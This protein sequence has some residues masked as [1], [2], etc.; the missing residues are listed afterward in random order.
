MHTRWMT[1]TV[2]GVVVIGCTLL[3]APPAGAQMPNEVKIYAGEN[4]KP[5]TL[6][7][8]VPDE[9]EIGVG[10]TMFLRIRGGAA[11]FSAAE[12]ARIVNTRLTYIL[13]YGDLDPDAVQ[14]IPVRGKPTI[15]VGN[16]RLITVY[17]C[18]AEAAGASSMEELATIWA[19]AT[20]CCLREIAPWARVQA[21][22]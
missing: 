5:V 18:D 19:A 10:G 21:E 12:R 1:A 2:V 8:I 15:Y 13:S 6:A 3:W 14:I 11:G 20:A 16:V 4:E 17:P 7:R 9:Y 22:G